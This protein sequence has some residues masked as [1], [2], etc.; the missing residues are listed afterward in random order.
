MTSVVVLNYIT[1]KETSWKKKNSLL[2]CDS[3]TSSLYN[4]FLTGRPGEHHRRERCH[5][6][7]RSC[8]LGEKWDQDGGTQVYICIKCIMMNI[9]TLIQPLIFIDVI[10]SN[11]FSHHE[12]ITAPARSLQSPFVPR[13]FPRESVR[14]WQSLSVRSWVRTPS[15]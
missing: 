1:Y 14:T 7:S 3:F 15:T 8:H 9:F 2:R 13:L 4:F 5:G 10:V 11:L 6:N 12:Y